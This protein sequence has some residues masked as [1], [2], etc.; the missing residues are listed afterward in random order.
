MREDWDWGERSAKVWETRSR[1]NLALGL[2]RR[3]PV[4][5]GVVS[6]LT[7]PGACHGGCGGCP[8]LNPQICPERSSI[9]RVR[10]DGTTSTSTD[11]NIRCTQ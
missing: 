7:K 11:C 3:R 8:R 9:L 1:L 10:L 4:L 2:G 6:L 5:L